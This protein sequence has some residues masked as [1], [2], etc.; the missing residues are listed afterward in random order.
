MDFITLRNEKLGKKVC[1]ALNK[2]FF[3]AYFVPTKEEILPKVL[4][5]IPPENSV[6]WGGSMTLESLGIKDALKERGYTLIDRDTASNP[7]DRRELMIKALSAGTFL[8]SS[9]AITEKGELF[10][11]DGAGNRV[12]ALCYGPKNVLVI[13]GINKVVRDMEEAY[14]K[15]RTFTAPVNAQRFCKTTPCS[16]SGECGDCINLESICAQFVETRISRPKG[17]IKV[18]LAGE[19]L[20]I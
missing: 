9:N 14:K 5:L 20:G 3:E 2:R 10:N 1:E 15:V 13:A 11:I 8:M 7:D 4:E 19:N 18:I 6:S 12:A 16:V 17:R